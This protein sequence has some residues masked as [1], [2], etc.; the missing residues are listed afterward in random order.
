MLNKVIYQSQENVRKDVS[1]LLV[2]AFPENER[3]P[4]DLFFENLKRD[5]TLLITY[6]KNEA[7]I[8]FASFILFEDIAYLFFLAVSP[9]YR[10]QGYGSE[11][12]EDLKEM[13]KDKV[14][15]LCYEEVNP[16]YHNYEERKIREAFY[17]RHGFQDNGFV[18][19]EW[20]VKFQS[21]Y[22][23]KHKVSFEKYLEIFKIGFGI[24]AEKYLKMARIS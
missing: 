10:H 8:G 9:I 23:G 2:E 11:I 5:N 4:V 6:Y 24:D 15:L 22:I 7:F 17:L 19:D 13:F 21:A 1:I 3:P 12:L 14:L 18:S 16:Q 20:G